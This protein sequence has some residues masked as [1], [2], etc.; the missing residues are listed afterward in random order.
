MLR[1]NQKGLRYMMI[2]VPVLVLG[3]DADSSYLQAHTEVFD[4]AKEGNLP[5]AY[6]GRGIVKFPNSIGFASGLVEGL[7]FRRYTGPRYCTD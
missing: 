7:S 3:S 1:I 6:T 2:V 4:R 5:R